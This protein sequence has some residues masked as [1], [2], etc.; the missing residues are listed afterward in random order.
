[1]EE[2]LKSN[3]VGQREIRLEKLEQLK[4]LGVNPYPAKSHKEY[5]NIDILNDFEKFEGKVVCLAGRIVAWREHGKLTF[6]D[7]RDQSGDIQ[8]M[9]RKWRLSLCAYKWRY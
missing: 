3:L 2:N 9:I 5:R 4:K 8:V 6:A 7:I 1:M